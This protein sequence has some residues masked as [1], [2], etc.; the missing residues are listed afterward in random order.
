MWH[1]LMFLTLQSDCGFVYLP[2][3]GVI[4]CQRR[5]NMVHKLGECSLGDRYEGFVIIEND[6][7]FIKAYRRKSATFKKDISIRLYAD[8]ML[9]Q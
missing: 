5:R 8:R 1:R 9:I 3:E 7:I 4:Q 2:D 6:K